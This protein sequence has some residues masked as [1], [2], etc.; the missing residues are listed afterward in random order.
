MDTGG[1][2]K[3]KDISL[4]GVSGVSGE[5]V[6][7]K[8]QDFVWDEVLSEHCQLPQVWNMFISVQ[9]NDV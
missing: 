3:M 5:R 6:V 1:M 7:N 2:T 8:I 4:K 9:F